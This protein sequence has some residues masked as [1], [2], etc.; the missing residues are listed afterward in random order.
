MEGDMTGQRPSGD[1]Y[2]ILGRGALLEE[3]TVFSVFSVGYFSG[4]GVWFWSLGGLLQGCTRLLGVLG[5]GARNPHGI[6]ELGSRTGSVP[7]W[8][9]GRFGFGQ[10][11]GRATER[12]TRGREF[13]IRQRYFYLCILMNM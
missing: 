9:G 3:R 4:F 8:Q 7:S 2:E 5:S 13:S 12:T 6:L 10:S 1:Y 11:L